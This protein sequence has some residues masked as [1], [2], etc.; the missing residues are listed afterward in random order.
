MIDRTFAGLLDRPAGFLDRPLLWDDVTG[1]WLSERRVAD[2]SLALAAKLER[3]EKGLAFLFATNTSATLVGFL[4][5]AAAGHAVALIDPTLP[6][7][8]LSNLLTRYQPEFLIGSEPLAGIGPV[9]AAEWALSDPTSE[10]PAIAVRRA[11]T[12]QPPLHPDLGALLLTSGTTGSAK[13]V[14]LSHTALAVNARQIAESLALTPNSVAIGHLP[15]HY[16][17]GLSVATSHLVSGGRIAFINDTLTSESFWTK[18]K[19]SDGTHFPGVPFHYSVLARLG[20][21]RVPPSVDTFTQAGGHL[22]RRIQEM[23]LTKANARGARVFVMYG[24]TEAA[25]RIACVPSD[26]LHQKLGSVGLA[27]P[28]G[29][30]SIARPDGTSL[31]TGETGLVAYE[32]ANVMLGYAES[33]SDLA[34]GDVMGGKLE[35]GD[36]GWMDGEGFLYLSGRAARFAKIA[37]LRLSLDDIERQL[38]SLGSVACVDLGDRIAAVFEGEIP[39]NAKAHTKALALANKIPPASF[40]LRAL[41]ELPRKANGKIDYARVKGAIDV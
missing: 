24:Q 34:Q 3:T 28:G 1:V 12:G 11:R 19:A 33:R 10:T 9:A 40:A 29:K 8:K 31:P 14:R 15:F 6:D 41:A 23:I 27:M 13:F 21:D 39:Q 37:G 35:T 2:L 25:P 20:F 7:D 17:Y 22:D 5:L 16:S 30:L 26:R 18:V 32:G 36:L 4:G 38:A